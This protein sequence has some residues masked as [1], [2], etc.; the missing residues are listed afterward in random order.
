MNNDDTII[1][2]FDMINERLYNIEMQTNMLLMNKRQTCVKKNKILPKEL[3]GIS[4]DIEIKGNLTDFTDVNRY[5]MINIDKIC[6]FYE[7]VDHNI[8]EVIRLLPKWIKSEHLKMVEELLIHNTVIDCELKEIPCKDLDIISYHT[9]V[10]D[11]ILSEYLQEKNK[12]I[13]DA[14][15]N[16]T[17][18]PTIIL[19]NCKDIN[20]IIDIIQKIYKDFKLKLNLGKV[21][22]IPVCKSW[23]NFYRIIH[24]DGDYNEQFKLVD[25][26]S[27]QIYYRYLLRMCNNKGEL[28]DIKDRGFCSIIYSRNDYDNL[29]EIIETNLQSK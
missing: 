2:V 4:F 18:N 22:I 8:D 12:N 15:S 6:G 23:I 24:G 26:A 28:D 20:H 19:Q 25:K 10:T 13:Y 1:K 11:Y 21:N 16:G 29:T 3:F 17:D 7:L 5:Y 9:N 14:F 27:L